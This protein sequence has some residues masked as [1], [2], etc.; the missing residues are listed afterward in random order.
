MNIKELRKKI[1]E[2]REHPKW[3]QLIEWAKTHSLPGFF[4]V[5][6]Y[7]IIVFLYNET[8]R[9]AIQVR[10]NSIAYSFLLALFPATIVLISLLPYLP[11]ANFVD[12]LEHNLNGF[13]PDHALHT[14]MEFIRDLTN[15][16]R[17]GLLSLG[18]VLAFFFASNGMM[19]LIDGF[20]KKHVQNVF[21]SRNFI[22]ER[23]IAIQLVIL[24]GIVLFLSIFFIILGN[25][26]IYYLSEYVHID[27]FTTYSILLTRWIAIIFLYYGCITIIY[28][29]GPALK[30]KFKVMSPGA[31]LATSLGIISS[32]L[33]S[34]Y[35]DHFGQFNELYGSLGVLLV[36][37]IWLRINAFIIIAGFELNAAITVNRDL[38]KSDN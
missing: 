2:L 4:A 14:I 9:N 34:I 16:P 12:Q 31:T 37:M 20:K 5:P 35:I 1:I 6:I 13:L 36:F 23:I 29:F 3:V 18:F 10:A 33:F 19:A 22:M 8:Q 26:L 24:L 28:R 27:K 11:I 30:E 15:T 25:Q 32:W 38:K 7:D 21:M 17:E